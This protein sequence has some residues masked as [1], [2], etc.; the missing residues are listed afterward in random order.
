M[1]LNQDDFTLVSEQL[2]KKKMYG[3][4]GAHDCGGGRRGPLFP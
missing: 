3:V 4:I 2:E 1:A